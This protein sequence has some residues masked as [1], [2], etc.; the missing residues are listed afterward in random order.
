MSEIVQILAAATSLLGV[1]TTIVVK[2]LPLLSERA[3]KRAVRL[4]RARR[5]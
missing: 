2:V 1:F 5:K 4:A 3:N